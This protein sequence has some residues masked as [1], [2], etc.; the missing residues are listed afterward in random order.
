MKDYSNNDLHNDNSNNIIDTSSNNI[1]LQ[2]I[3]FVSPED[4]S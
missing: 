1:N 4:M 2:I 3:E